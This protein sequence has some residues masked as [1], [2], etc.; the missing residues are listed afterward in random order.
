MTEGRF[1][2]VNEVDLVKLEDA[3][4]L[5]ILRLKKLGKFT[6][7]TSVLLY[8]YVDGE[9]GDT[10]KWEDPF[11][12][13]IQEPNMHGLYVILID[14]PAAGLSSDM[15]RDFEKLVKWERNPLFYAMP[16]QF[17]D[18]YLVPL[19]LKWGA[20]P[21][22]VK[23]EM[24]ALTVK[25]VESG[26]N[27]YDHSV[28]IGPLTEANVEQAVATDLTKFWQHRENRRQIELSIRNLATRG[29]FVNGILAAFAFLSPAGLMNN[30]WTEPPY[31]RRGLSATIIQ[32]L[33][34]AIM[35]LGCIPMA[36]CA[37]TNDSVRRLFMKLGFT[38]VR[39]TSSVTFQPKQKQVRKRE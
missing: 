5:N 30:V 39:K 14:F 27:D 31:R 23:C 32:S 33:S 4:M 1:D 9:K 22:R 19:C 26:Q 8:I 36:Q 16:D 15:I 17:C 12:V 28:R 29:A 6:D 38:L 20:E 10:A 21:K 13:C 24:Y 2:L 3:L 35:E 37:A 34:G 18:N 11:T 7:E 25:N